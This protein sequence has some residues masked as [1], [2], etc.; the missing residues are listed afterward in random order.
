MEKEECKPVAEERIFLRN[1][2]AST[3]DTTNSDYNV[4][5]PIKHLDAYSQDVSKGTCFKTKNTTGIKEWT[6]VDLI[7]RDI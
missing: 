6:E 3:V 2:I 5:N 1:P 7:D 4:A